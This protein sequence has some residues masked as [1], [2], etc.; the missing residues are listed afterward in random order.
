MR[1]GQQNRRGRG[2]G[3]NNNSNTNRKPQNPLSR[4]YESS[5]PDV[6]IRGTASQIAEKYS[7]LARDASSAG[8]VI[9]AE[10]YLQHAEHYNR[11]I[12]AAQ[13]QSSQPAAHNGTDA[14]HALNGAH[15]S[16]RDLNGPPK[17]QPQPY[18]VQ[19]TLTE[20]PPETQPD[21]RNQK[22]DDQPLMEEKP[23]KD[24]ALAK[25]EKKE[26]DKGRA[27]GESDPG[28]RRRRR[29][30]SSSTNGATATDMSNDKDKSSDVAEDGQ[31][32]DEVTAQ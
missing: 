12:M 2:R 14:A 22:A 7:T 26:T 11:I 17:D 27:S 16:N 4:N 20:Q 9:M 3:G 23:A 8:D 25:E 28:R 18:D 31:S 1:Q 19:P 30:T 5:G 13:A 6:K 29:Y 21:I 10:N 15:R 24:G 32:A